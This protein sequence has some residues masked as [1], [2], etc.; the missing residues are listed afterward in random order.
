[1]HGDHGCERRDL[2]RKFLGVVGF[3]LQKKSP[4]ISERGVLCG[5]ARGLVSGELKSMGVGVRVVRP[6]ALPSGP[7]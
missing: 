6:G 7:A 5:P 2:T 4:D 1:M 3:M